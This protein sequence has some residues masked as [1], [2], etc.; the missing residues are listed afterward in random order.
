MDIS[1]KNLN[2]LLNLFNKSISTRSVLND[3]EYVFPF[4]NF[5]IIGLSNSLADSLLEIIS[6]LTA[7]PEIFLPKHF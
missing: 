3:D 4:S 2:R 6:F 5:L 1:Y 7:L